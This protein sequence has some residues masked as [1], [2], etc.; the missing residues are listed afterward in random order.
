MIYKW[1]HTSDKSIALLKSAI[2]CGAMWGGKS[3]GKVH[4]SVYLREQN[5][6]TPHEYF[7][8]SGVEV[9]KSHTHPQL[10]LP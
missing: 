9:A 1:L 5:R 6:L 8:F 2:K 3:P 10:L 4:H 7:L